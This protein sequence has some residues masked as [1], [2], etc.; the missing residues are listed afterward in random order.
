M[1]PPEPL[2][3]IITPVCDPP[4]DV[5][6]ETIGSVRAQ[7]CRSWE[8]CLADDAS[9]NPRV[10]DILA[11]AAADDDR[12]RVARNEARGGIV[13]AS[14]A[15]VALAS[16]EWLVFLD[17]DDLMRADALAK[18]AREI[19]LKP[20]ADYIYSD[21]DK[22]DEN[23]R[24]FG[25]FLK[26][27]W[28]PDRLR[29]HMYTA[30][31]SVV[32]HQTYREVGGFRDGFDGAQDWDLVLRVTERARRVVH[33]PEVLYHWRTVATSVAGHVDAK[34][35]AY[36]AA[37]RAVEGQVARLG[38]DARVE[39]HP[40]V[41]G[42]FNLAP[43]L[44]REPHVSVIVPTRG[45]RRDLRGID[46]ALVENCLR[47]LAERT[48]YDAWDVVCV[49]DEPYVRDAKND[50]AF[51]G[52]RLSI[53]EYD[54]PF[55]FSEKINRGVE[56]AAGELLLSLN[57]DIEVREPDWLSRLVTHASTPG[58][59]VVGPKLLFEDDRIQH[60]GIVLV[61]GS[62]AHI[63]YG[64]PP[65][66]LGY[67]GQAVL[68][69]NA[70]AVT[71]ACLLTTRE[72][73]DAVGGMSEDFPV[74]YN[75]LDYCLKVWEAGHRVV[76]AGDVVLTHLEHATR[77]GAVSEAELDHFWRR[78][79]QYMEHDPFM[80]PRLV[81]RDSDVMVPVVSSKDGTLLDRPGPV[82]VVRQQGVRAL[83]S[84]APTMLPAPFHLA[85][86]AGKRLLGRAR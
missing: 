3:S 18:V 9:T 39:P 1:P 10:R 51:L 65:E 24:H 41:P 84:H 37:Q 11:L 74:N 77:E 2:F 54:A 40:Q 19:S 72:A 23:G 35:W 50:L 83:R 47:G 68:A 63:Y 85:Y 49:A 67:F 64:L 70:L 33:I 60:A 38:I 15:A 66:T 55:N 7:T 61:K 12:I 43:A 59:G 14:R 48:D 69:S 81:L 46:T 16:G 6:I 20:D 73:F 13:A 29:S 57:D 76:F 52:D 30:H 86:R 32:R 53:V 75:D 28:S 34:P 22:V 4:P 44:S 82:E 71:G 36:A 5:L 58:V 79:P 26:P 21:E 80:H 8:L 42:T 56:R 17:H 45:T 62:P 31:L 25:P 78:W 27:D